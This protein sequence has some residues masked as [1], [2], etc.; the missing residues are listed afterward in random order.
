MPL[1][2]YGIRSQGSRGW[3]GP[4]SRGPPRALRAAAAPSPA[5]PPPPQGLAAASL[6]HSGLGPRAGRRRLG[7]SQRGAEQR[8]AEGQA[9][10]AS[11]RWLHVGG[12][13]RAL[14]ADGCSRDRPGREGRK[15]ASP[16]LPE[17]GQS[18]GGQ[19]KSRGAFGRKVPHRK[20][21][22]YSVNTSPA[23]SV[24]AEEL[25]AQE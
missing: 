11:P 2:G 12:A 6:T 10:C 22:S 19:S 13:G 24:T 5:A 21:R 17:P 7:R 25:I 3:Q 9:G 15:G 23:V 4:P 8:Q 1:G 16:A 20:M 18:G 14:P